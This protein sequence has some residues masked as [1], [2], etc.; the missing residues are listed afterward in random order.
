M[1]I[2]RVFVGGCFWVLCYIV[3]CVALDVTSEGRL[4]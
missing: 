3:S 2:E 1:G 4:C